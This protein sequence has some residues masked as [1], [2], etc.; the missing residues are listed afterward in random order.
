MKRRG[1]EEEREEKKGSVLCL[2][3]TQT[4]PQEVAASRGPKKINQ[5]RAHLNCART[6]S[7]S[8][9]E[10]TPL[11]WLGLACIMKMSNVPHARL[12]IMFAVAFFATALHRASFCERFSKSANKTWSDFGESLILVAGAVATV[13]VDELVVYIH[14]RRKIAP[15]F[16]PSIRRM[17]E[18][19]GLRFTVV[20]FLGF[21][22][23]V[24]A[25][26]GISFTCGAVLVRELLANQHGRRTFCGRARDIASV[27]DLENKSTGG[28]RGAD[29]EVQAVHVGLG[30]GAACVRVGTEK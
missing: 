15:S 19:G 22:G 28:I 18:F 24:F 17:K 8:R 23:I 21:Y 10:K 7:V 25:A 30:G 16:R 2:K 1:G 4:E 29:S 5:T 13:A 6:L 27:V 12:N 11:A 26:F 14:V 3:G 20:Q 9:K